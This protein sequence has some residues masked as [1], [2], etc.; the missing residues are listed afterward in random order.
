[1]TVRLSA[2]FEDHI[3]K[4]INNWKMAKKKQNRRR[5]KVSS[6]NSELSF[7]VCSDSSDNEVQ[8]EQLTCSQEDD[9]DDDEIPLTV[10]RSKQNTTESDTTSLTSQSHST[11]S[12]LRVKVKTP[13]L[14]EE[15]NPGGP[16]SS[17][18][19]SQRKRTYRTS[20]DEEEEEFS[21]SSSDDDEQFGHRKSLRQR[22]VKKK[23]LLYETS[24]SDT[25][26]SLGRRRKR[27]RKP[28]DSDSDSKSSRTT[29]NSDRNFS[30]SSRGRVRKF[31]ERAKYLFGKR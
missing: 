5:T 11:V 27:I 10:L 19:G 17:S 21:P 8:P 6:S 1:M 26:C 20:S 25:N 22:P 30:V 23:I 4:I 12:K 14:E 16:F 18:S 29:L 24:D 3:R 13:P 28:S 15:Y 9:S 2:I 31:T 7:T